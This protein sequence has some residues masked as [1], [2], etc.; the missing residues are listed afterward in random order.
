MKQN[1]ISTLPTLR[2]EHLENIFNIHLDENNNNAY[3]YNLLQTVEI[4]QHLP[5]AYY[6]EYM[7]TYEDTWPFISYKTYGTP[8]LW[9][10]IVSANNIVNPTKLPTPGS[11][12]KILRTEIVQNILQQTSVQE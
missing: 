11:T 10:I 5:K 12:I 3:F 4:P 8:N 7:V 2:T 6:K 1:Q 9:W